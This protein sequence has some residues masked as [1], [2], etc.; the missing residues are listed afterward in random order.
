M[1]DKIISQ[2][3]HVM[4][5]QTADTERHLQSLLMQSLTTDMP[6]DDREVLAIKTACIGCGTYLAAF[7]LG[8]LVCALLGSC[9]T[10]GH[11]VREQ[12]RTV[13]HDTVFRDRLVR[14]SIFRSDSIYV[15][16]WQAG[17][18]VRIVTDHWHTVYHDIRQRDT[19]YVAVRDT[20][21]V[22]RE[23]TRDVPARL[24]WWQQLRI[25]AGGV[26]IWLAVIL[27][28]AWLARRKIHLP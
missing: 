3:Q 1:K 26:A 17:D 12:E 2:Y 13:R 25:H 22:V 11:T 6:D 27:G 20:V 23:T 21:T 19:A 24:T 14:D 28:V 16:E 5:G 18:T 7:I 15:H 8:L 10:V 9:T 4:E